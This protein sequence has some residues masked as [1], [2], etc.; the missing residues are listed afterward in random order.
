MS[1][2]LGPPCWLWL[3]LVVGATPLPTAQDRGERALV[4]VSRRPTPEGEQWSVRCEEAGLGEIVREIA[5]KAD[6]ALEGSEL[7]AFGAKL[8]VDLERRPLEQVLDYVLGNQGLRHELVGGA[9]RLLPASHDPGE[10]LRLAQDAWRVVA[11]GGD[12]TAAGRARL[13]QGNLAEARGDL[14][15]AYLAYSELAAEEGGEDS[16]EATFRAGKVLERMGHWAE[17]AQHFRTLAGLDGAQRFHSRARLELARAS[18]QL[19]DAGSALH[20]LN[21]LAANYAS[22]DPVELAERRL[23]RAE[24]FNATQEHV[25]ALRVLESGEVVSAPSAA[26]RSLEIRATALEGLGFQVE[27]A[28]AWLIFAREASLDEARAG[29]FARAARLSLEAGDELGTLFVCREAAKAG[30]DEGLGSLERDAR[31][32]LGL[33]ERDAPTTIH[34]RLE[35]AESL[36]ERGE[37]HKA[38]QVFEGLYLA[39]GAFPEGDQVRVLAG[40]ARIVLDR[41]GLEAAIEILARARGAAEDPDVLQELDRTAAGLF[42]AEGRFDEAV[43]AYRGVY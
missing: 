31:A 36:L 6:L 33:E 3:T 14:E 22:I 37:V 7:L 40:W 42:E 13:A 1:S 4:S 17:A 12:E 18:I 30:A 32:R 38:G 8:S 29:A 25:E 24:A 34:E 23:V 43:E 27:A 20:L 39:R 10:L 2:F 19:G 11:A 16:H 15:G 5:R 28:R 9:L 21:F 35:L 26:A 41:A